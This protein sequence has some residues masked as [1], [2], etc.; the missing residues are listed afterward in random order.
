MP[1]WKRTILS[2]S[3]SLKDD[4]V[5]THH[6]ITHTLKIEHNGLEL[7]ATVVEYLSILEGDGK[8][9]DVKVMAILRS[10]LQVP[11]PSLTVF[12]DTTKDLELAKLSALT[13]INHLAF[14]IVN[15]LGTDLESPESL[16]KRAYR[17]YG[18]TTNFKNYQ[19]LPMPEWEALTP[20][21][22]QAWINAATSVVKPS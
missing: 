12:K 4:E 2:G 16:G 8:F 15:A 22:R 17:A 10:I 19:G 3:V 18:H 7:V 20:I 1:E 6:P 11:M 13:Y 5:I 9:F 14:T 21:I